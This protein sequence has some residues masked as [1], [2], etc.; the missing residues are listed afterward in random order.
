MEKNIVWY[1]VYSNNILHQQSQ[2]PYPNFTLLCRSECTFNYDER[3][4]LYVRDGTWSKV[5]HY[6]LHCVYTVNRVKV[7]T[8]GPSKLV[9]SLLILLKE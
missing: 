9:T 7:K 2:P 6:T 1:R 8:G 4:L 5:K 3:V